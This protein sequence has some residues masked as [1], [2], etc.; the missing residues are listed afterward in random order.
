[1]DR[2]LKLLIVDLI[3][4]INLDYLKKIVHN[5]FTTNIQGGVQYLK[6]IVHNLFTTNI[7]GG[8]L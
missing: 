7:Q 2:K 8:V 5:L 3:V 6:K 1:M 4:N